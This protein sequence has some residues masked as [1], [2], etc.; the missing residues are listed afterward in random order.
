MKDIVPEH[1]IQKRLFNKLVGAETLRYS[2]LKPKELEANLF[3]YHLKELIKMGLV[4]KKDRAYALSQKGRTTATRFSIR[5]QTIRVMP[6]TL[7]VIALQS[8]E[9][10]WCLYK[11]KRQPYIGSLGFPS[12]KIHLGDSLADAAYRELEEKCGYVRDVHLEWK[13]TFNLVENEQDGSLKNHVIGQVWHGFVKEKKIAENHAGVTFWDDWTSLDYT[14]F[15]PGFKEIIQGLATK[16]F[17]HFEL[18]K[19]NSKSID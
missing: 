12:G 6:S 19:N 3:M 2:E 7:S 18:V 4:E 11:R 10:L 15:I 5:E 16:N 13:G 8:N 17:F 9:G 14:D 1:H